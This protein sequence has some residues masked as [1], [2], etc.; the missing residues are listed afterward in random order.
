MLYSLF[1]PAVRQQAVFGGSTV[2]PWQPYRSTPDVSNW[3][4]LE[5]QLMVDAG[6]EGILFSLR[7]KAHIATA[8]NLFECLQLV[9][10]AG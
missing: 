3:D 8:G 4:D 1:T 9:G 10:S 6:P 2:M 7:S 5:P